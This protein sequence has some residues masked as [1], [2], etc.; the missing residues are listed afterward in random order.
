MITRL[1]VQ[2]YR[3]LVDAEVEMRP[4]G[5]MIGANG[6]GKASLMEVLSLLSAAANNGFADALGRLG[7]FPAV[8]NPG[9]E[10]VVF[11]VNAGG[12]ADAFFYELILRPAS[13]GFAITG[14]TLRVEGQERLLISSDGSSTG[15]MDEAGVIRRSERISKP[16]IFPHTGQ[17]GL[18]QKFREALGGAAY[19]PLDVRPIAPVRHPQAVQPARRPSQDGQD[20]VSCLLNLRETEPD[21]YEDVLAA[22][23]AAFP[24]FETLQFPPVAAGT[25]SLSW[26]ERT[27][28]SPLYPS[29]L[30]DG[31]LRFLWLATLLQS[32]GLDPLTMLDEP[33]ASL[34]PELLRLLVELLRE[35]SDRSQILA[36]T[37]SDR[38]IRFLEPAEVL[39][40]DLNEDG[41]SKFTWGD[42]LNLDHWL[43]E[44]SLEDLWDHGVLELRDR[45]H[46]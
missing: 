8:R 41:S 6:S 3:R 4:F 1:R 46:P 16:M 24:S 36:T 17:H 40:V 11:T 38:L 30:S 10:R 14:E 12:A 39:I 42:Q 27:L 44:Y 23:R 43:E 29:Q 31:I 28:P 7:G 21:R 2:G 15:M 9:A 35:A 33:D 25:I 37:H 19:T 45:T 32:P 34:H 13:M 26:K 22:L 20:L 5:V 18:I